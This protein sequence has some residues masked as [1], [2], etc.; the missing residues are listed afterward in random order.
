MPA[1]TPRPP[2]QPGDTAPEF[3]LPA[4]HR[5]GSVSLA[6]YRGRSAV[7]LAI[8]RGLYCPFCRRA[9]A[10][11]GT[12]HD[13]LLKAG[14]ESLVVVATELDNARL[15]F[16]YRPARVPIAADPELVTH[17]AY[18]LPQPPLNEQTMQAI[19]GL[20]INPTG[21][22][23]EPMM[24]IAAA[25]A[26]DKIHGYQPT[27]TDKRDFERQGILLKGQFLLDSGGIVRWAN[28]EC[29]NEGL[30]GFGRFPTEDELLGATRALA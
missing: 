25:A 30:P 23:P 27:A 6:D 15:Y 19:E 20:R 8:F 9:I 1:N 18:G 2:L 5:E 26:L 4:V 21:E 28:I 17:R 16:K 29:G 22:L 14:V 24:P 7:L 13:K 10:Q 12:A 11:F 3:T